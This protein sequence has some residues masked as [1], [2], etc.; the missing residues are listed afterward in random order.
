MHCEKG[1]YH[2]RQ[3]CIVDVE[4]IVLLQRC[5]LWMGGLSI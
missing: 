1:G 2:G 3:A 5:I 4:K